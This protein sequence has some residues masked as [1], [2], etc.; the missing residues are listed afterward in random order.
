RASAS[1]AVRAAAAARRRLYRESV[2]RDDL[3]AI[4]RS[5]REAVREYLE[6]AKANDNNQ[7]TFRM[8]ARPDITRAAE[9]AALFPGDWWG[10]VVYSC[11]DSPSGA[12][13]VAP[14][15]QHPL[16]P[17]EAERV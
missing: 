15:F 9:T 1:D 12:A 8:G 2:T 11:F 16:P 3:F 7:W 17:P 4:V 5:R 10:V 14:H 13:T 6:W